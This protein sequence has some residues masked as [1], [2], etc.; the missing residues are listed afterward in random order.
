[1]TRISGL[2]AGFVG[3]L[4]LA[5]LFGPVLDSSGQEKKTDKKDEKKTEQKKEGKKT[6]Q[7]KEEKKI[8]EKKVE[9]FKPD[10]PQSEIK[11]HG[12]WITA[13]SLSGDGKLLATASRDR[14]VKVWDLAQK[15]DIQTLKGSPGDVKSVLFIA[16]KVAS[17]TGAWDKKKKAWESEIRIWDPATGKMERALHGHAD[18]IEAAALSRDGKILVTASVDQT[19]KVWDVAGG[20]E[21]QTL[22][23]HT[24]AVLTIAITADGKK[25]ATGSADRTVKIWDAVTGKELASFKIERIVKVPAPKTMD[26]DKK[27]AAKDKKVEAKDKKKEADPKAKKETEVKELG[28][29]FTAVAFSPD[30]KRLAAGN[31]DGDIKIYDVDG[32]K[33]VKEIKAPDGI[34]ALAFT[35]DGAKLASGG[36]DKTIKIWDVASGK[37]LNTI[38]AHMETV[39]ALVFTADGQQVISAGL[40]GMVKIWNTSKK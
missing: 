2:L 14:T 11:A 30:G 39:T 35:A 40:D 36:W 22:K 29:D 3:C 8:E 33:E 21:T 24:G 13:I 1:M 15:K 28:R 19:A 31:L 12:N 37:D 20:K 26:K 23:G 9:P 7:K 6:E 27:P 17:T 16:G 38:K 32:A 34:W 10:V 18:A 5:F 4:A 25:V